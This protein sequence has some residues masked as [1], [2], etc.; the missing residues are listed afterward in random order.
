MDVWLITAFLGDKSQL[1]IYA[2]T[3]SLSQLI[4]LIPNAFHTV[5][6]T[7]ISR[8]DTVFQKTKVYS[9]SKNIFFLALAFA[10]IGYTLSFW[11]V[12]LFFSTGYN[13]VIGIFPYLLPGIVIFAP[14]ILWSGFFA[15]QRRI[16]INFRS[17]LYGFILCII[18]NLVLIPKLQI[19]G[20]AIASTCSYILSSVYLFWRF[21]R[22]ET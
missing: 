18:L 8:S 6:F 14:S 12:P 22:S 21:R 13:D 2:L 7:E 5:I 20:A 1:G 3:V 16:D 11:L 9:W 17:S 19:I 4:W 10:V 15:G